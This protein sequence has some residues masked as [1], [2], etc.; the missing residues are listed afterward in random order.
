[1]QPNV[2]GASIGGMWRGRQSGFT[3]LE[4]L[5]ALVV[6]GLL[7]VA[8][9]QGVR[10]GVQAWQTQARTV[11]TQGDLLAVDRTLRG[12]IERADPGQCTQPLTHHCPRLSFRRRPGAAG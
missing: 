11:D 12:M 2:L 1:M 10:F 9:T 4:L 8:I 5:A 6:L 3:L 7:M